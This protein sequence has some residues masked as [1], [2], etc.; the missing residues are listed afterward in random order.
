MVGIIHDG[1]CMR[2]ID[3]SMFSVATDPSY[4]SIQHYASICNYSS[5]DKD[6]PATGRGHGYRPRVSN[7]YPENNFIPV[8]IL[9][10]K[11]FGKGFVSRR[12]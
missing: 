10:A 1:E 12:Q 5:A 7:S 11:A 8:S 3:L 4:G 2:S 6:L 9:I